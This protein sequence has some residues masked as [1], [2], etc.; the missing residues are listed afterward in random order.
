[1]RQ[2]VRDDMMGLLGQSG[3]VPPIIIGVVSRMVPVCGYSCASVNVPLEVGS[4]SVSLLLLTTLIVW[5]I[6]AV[7]V[8]LVG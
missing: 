7:T 2:Q 4:L 6:Y 3:I 5:M 8:F 1:M